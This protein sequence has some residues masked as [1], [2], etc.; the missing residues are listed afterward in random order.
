M[1]GAPG[2]EC[3]LCSECAPRS[4]KP[5]ATSATND[6]FGGPN[7]IQGS[8]LVLYMH[9]LSLHVLLV[10]HMCLRCRKESKLHVL[11]LK[12]S[13]IFQFFFD[14][15]TETLKDALLIAAIE[16]THRS[17]SFSI[18]KLAKHTRRCEVRDL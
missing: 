11:H 12:I 14:I 17:A 18:L 10:K 2:V 9:M 7:G 3:A 5:S 15:S 4:R 6:V 1:V 13:E 16:R 8:T